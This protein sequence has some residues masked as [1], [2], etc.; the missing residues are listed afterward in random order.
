MIRTHNAVVAV[1]VVD[2]GT[3]NPVAD[4]Y[5]RDVDAGLGE[6]VDGKRNSRAYPALVVE[7][8]TKM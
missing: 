2:D 5:M 3:G 1:V 7:V 8:E 6:T 4:G